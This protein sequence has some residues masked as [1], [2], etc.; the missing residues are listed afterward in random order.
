L[1]A[2]A[3]RGKYTTAGYIP[4]DANA[5]Q[6]EARTTSLAPFSPLVVRPL[7]VLT[8]SVCQTLNV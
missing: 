5:R 7:S 8:K 6:K 2:S 3:V 1:G 4:S